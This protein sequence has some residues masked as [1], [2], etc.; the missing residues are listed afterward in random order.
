MY[1]SVERV[2]DSIQVTVRSHVLK[3]IA[4]GP[5]N[6]PIFPNNP[7]LIQN[8]A[9]LIIDPFKRQVIVLSHQYGGILFV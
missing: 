1:F 6:V 4:Y 8:F 7:K 9:Y 5:N 3:V 2:T